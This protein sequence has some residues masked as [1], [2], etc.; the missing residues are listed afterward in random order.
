M[1]ILRGFL[2]N[3]LGPGEEVFLHRPRGLGK[4]IWRGPVGVKV[5]Q[6]VLHA[7]YFGH[8]PGG[9]GGGTSI[10]PGSSYNGSGVR[11]IR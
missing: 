5:I 11:S 6:K 9:G 7:E 4:V 8:G 10:D 3:D 2:D 1:G